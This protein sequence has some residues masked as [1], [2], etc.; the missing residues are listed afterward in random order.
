MKTILIYLGLAIAT[1]SNA[2]AGIQCVGQK[3]KPDSSVE[4]IRLTESEPVNVGENILYRV[5]I[6][7]G[8]PLTPTIFSVMYMPKTQEMSMSLID[9]VNDV[10][11]AATS[12]TQP[13]QTYNNLRFSTVRSGM[14]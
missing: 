13:G 1:S 4:T 9:Y 12:K 11:Y 6:N 7:N 2:L 8:S 10:M 14:Q 5:T 3:Y